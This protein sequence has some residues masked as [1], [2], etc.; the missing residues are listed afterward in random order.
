MTDHDALVRAVCQHP[1]DDTPRLVFADYLDDHGE[2]DRAAFVRAQV[3]LARTPAWE[4]FAVLCRHRRTDWLTGEPFRHTLPELPPGAGVR[5][6]PRPFHRGFGYRAEVRSV[7]DWDEFGLP[8]FDRAPVGE[9]HLW[10]AVPP[11]DWLGRLRTVHFTANPVEPCRAVRAAAGLA[12]VHFHRADHPGLEFLVNDLLASPPGPTVGGLHFRT[13]YTGL[14][15]LFEALAPA[16][17][18]RLSLV[19]MG[20]TPALIRAWCNRTGTDGLFELDLTDNYALGSERGWAASLLLLRNG[21]GFHTLRLANCGVGE[22][23]VKA[24]ARVENAPHLRLLDLSRNP[25]GGRA[26]RAARLLAGWPHLA[27]LRSL[28]LS[29][30]RLGDAAVR[31][32]TKATFWPNLVELDLRGNPVS[33]VGAG[34]LL[35]ADVPPDLTALLLDPDPLGPKAAGRL[36]GHFGDR[37]V[38]AGLS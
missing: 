19:N 36:R 38:F 30:C 20:L 2:H 7:A 32:L 14:E 29:R 21:C 18:R 27:G 34:Y 35:K 8:L 24:L 4:P 3:E 28:D 1:D 6:H 17:V 10:Q 5:W 12:D 33:A 31:H 22:D 9:L 23:G 11:G 25:L 16:E 15:E 13:G 37:V 26:A